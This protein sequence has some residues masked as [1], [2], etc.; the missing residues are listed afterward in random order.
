T[1]LERKIKVPSN[2][3]Y[4]EIL[5]TDDEKYGGSGLLNPNKLIPEK[6]DLSNQE[7]EAEKENTLLYEITIM[8]PPLTIILLKPV[9]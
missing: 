8:I 1:H 3:N 9:F 2:K 6:I 7:E 5:N 4:K